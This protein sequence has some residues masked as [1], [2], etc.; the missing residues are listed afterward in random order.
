MY[1]KYDNLLV[2]QTSIDKKDVKKAQRLIKEAFREMKMGKFSD[3]ELEYA[4]KSFVF[5]LNLSLDNETGILNNYIFHVYDHLP[6]ISER[7]KMV[8]DVT[9]D[10]II[11]V[12]N[13][14]KPNIFFVLESEEEHGTN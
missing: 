6:F 2:I 13:K 1:L 10:E 3:D 4:K 7:I 9:R 5:S 11:Q 14:I 8:D 12:S